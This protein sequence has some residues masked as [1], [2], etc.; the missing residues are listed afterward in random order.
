MSGYSFK[1]KID[2]SGGKRMTIERFQLRCD[3]TLKDKFSDT[4]Q[5]YK[6][7]CILYYINDCLFVR[8]GDISN[9]IY[10]QL[11]MDRQFFKVNQGTLFVQ[12]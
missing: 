3:L 4:W 11:E 5:D 9:P 8:E 1:E 7:G 10:L 6:K 12:I 2:V